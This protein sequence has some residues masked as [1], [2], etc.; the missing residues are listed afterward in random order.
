MPRPYVLLSAAVSLD[1]CLDTPPGQPRLLLSNEEDFDR[2]DSVRAS[3]DAVLIGAGTLRADDPR[4]QV[5]S[6]GRRAARVGAGLPAHPMKATVTRGG[7]LDPDRRFWHHGGTKVVYAVGRAARDRAVAAVGALATVHQVAQ[8]DVWPQ[9]L[10]HLHG[11]GVR[12]L[13][14]EGGGSVHTQFLRQGLADELQ[15][16]VAPVIVG[17]ADAPR[18]FGPGGYPGGPEHR[19]ALAESRRIGDVTLLRY[20]THRRPGRGARATAADAV[21]LA[22]ACALAAHCPPSTT[23]FSV[24]AVVVSADGRELARGHSREG[25]DPRVHAEQAALAKVPGD[26]GL[27]GATV[28]SSLEPCGRRASSPH[29]CAELIAAAG[30]RRVVTA[31][32]EPDTFVPGANGTERLRER[33]ITVVELPEYAEAGR[34]PNAHLSPG[35]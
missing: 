22:Q 20:A 30:I 28:Y 1:G 12:R 33:G 16:V 35:E 26:P 21:W 31:W 4:V 11:L 17:G 29:P 24:G 13:M 15:L 14:V 3:C 6:A 34:A 27:A 7:D 9:V 32:R 8:E 2:V 19:L 23:A 25:G 5:A 10:E 18:M